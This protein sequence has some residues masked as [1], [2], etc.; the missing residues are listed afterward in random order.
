M[1]FKTPILNKL[2]PRPVWTGKTQQAPL[3]APF[4]H[5]REWPPGA[6][7]HPDPWDPVQGQIPTFFSLVPHSHLRS[8]SNPDLSHTSFPQKFQGGSNWHSTSSNKGYC[9][10]LYLFFVHFVKNVLSHPLSPHLHTWRN[11][12]KNLPTGVLIYSNS[13][14]T[15]WRG[16]LWPWCEEPGAGPGSEEKS[17]E[18]N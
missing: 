15:A 4:P 3:L 2:S 18:I 7:G 16:G 13:F 8:S 5:L 12:Y 6:S 17:R 9:F 1:S 10:K 11:S 14:T